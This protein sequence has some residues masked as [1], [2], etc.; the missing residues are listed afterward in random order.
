[1]WFRPRHSGL[2]RGRAAWHA[3]AVPTFVVL[4]KSLHL[5]PFAAALLPIAFA[6]QPATNPTQATDQQP[7]R[8]ALRVEIY[9]PAGIHV[10]SSKTDVEETGDRYVIKADLATRVFA[11]WFVDM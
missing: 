10:V 7:E 2:R 6:A 8:I 3:T 5:L 1:S 11:G 9:G 4:M